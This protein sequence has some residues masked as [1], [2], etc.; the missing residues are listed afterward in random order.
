MKKFSIRVVLII[1]V[2]F[3]AF[4]SANVSIAQERDTTNKLP[5]EELGSLDTSNII[6]EEVAQEKPAEVEN[7]EEVPTTD[8]LMQ[9]PEVL[10][11]PVADSDDTDL[12][13]VNSG[14]YWTLYYNTANGEY[15]LRMFGNVPSS[16]P[17]AWNSYLNRIKHIEIEE[18]TL[19]GN[20]ASYFKTT[21]DGFRVLESVR[22]EQCN[23]SGVT[24]FASAFYSSTLQKVIIRDNDYPTAP[25]LLTT[26]SMFSYATNLTEIDLSG[27]DTSAVTNMY[28][29]FNR[30]S[31]LEEL[32]V[33]HFDTSSVTN[34]SY[35]FYDNRNLE[36]LDVSNFDT[37]SVTTM[38]SMFDECNS[39]EILDVSNWDTSSV[40]NMYAMFRYCTSLKE[41]AVSNWE[42]S[43]VT[44]MGV[45]F[46]YC[47][48]LKELDIS[49]FDTSSVTNMYAMFVGSAGL[50]ELD[51]SN[52][53]TSSVTNMQAMFEN[54]TGLGELD[55]SNFDTSSVTTMQKMFDGCTSLE[56]LDLSNFDT[57]SVTTMAYM[58]R[59]CTALK[60]LYLDHFTTPKTITDM[61]TG[62]TALTYLFVSHNLIG[63]AGLENTSWYDE[64][65]WV[66]FSNYAQLQSYHWKQSEPT[67][68]RKGAFLSLTM[69]AMGG[70]FEDMEEQKVQNK[71]SGEYWDE[72]V[73][74]K[75]GHYFDGWYLDRNF[76]NK[77][78]FS[79]PATVSATLYAKWVENYTVV[80][81]ASISLNEATE[82]KVEG[83]NRGSKTLSVGLN[84]TATSVSE[85]NE[86]TLANTADTTIQCLAPLSWDGSENNPKNAILTLAPGLEIT[87][88]DAVMA[89]ETPENIQ[90]GTY[91]GNLVFSINYE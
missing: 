9:N 19:T 77:F 58:F 39:L 87:E 90:A 55:V 32:D 56:E 72:I 73:P 3:I 26:E 28:N 41:L 79:L 78:D 1:S 40:T 47:T 63:F 64:K 67:G 76:T 50:E 35:M 69:D 29:M 61:F 30:C 81:P 46:A 17:T 12:T 24:S 14:A 66:Q 68:Y 60:S 42:T 80:I 83:I 38:Q 8:E 48:S 71:V 34:M 53:D 18:A 27:L 51:V 43:S 15:S 36:V 82:L 33:S 5:E 75:E 6:A 44:T 54:C 59:N 25:S 52:F 4:G 13:V 91:T 7:L 89:I 70:Q 11:Q 86:L 31:A 57:S 21:T 85:S 22:I 37:S 16:R 88:G 84:R 62:T 2:L 74:V 65:N 20:F 49:N 10:E 45:Q 23:L